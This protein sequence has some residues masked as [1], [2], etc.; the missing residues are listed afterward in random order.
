MA[1]RTGRSTSASGNGFELEC[2]RGFSADCLVRK[3]MRT[4]MRYL[5]RALSIILLIVVLC[6]F[7]LVVLTRTPLVNRILRDKVIAFVATNYRGAL[8]IAQIEGSVW[9]SL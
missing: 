7:A 6:I 9:G 2:K 4:A 5:W 8:K 3:Q 1:T